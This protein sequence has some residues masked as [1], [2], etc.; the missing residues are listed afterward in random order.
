M[1]SALGS[2][3]ALFGVSLGLFVLISLIVMAAGQGA[4]RGQEPGPVWLGGPGRGE[5]GVSTSGIVLVDRTPAWAPGT[6]TDWVAAART[7]EPGRRTGGACAG[8]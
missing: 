2:M 5:H 3:G 8:W 6:A 4:P 1:N 7:A